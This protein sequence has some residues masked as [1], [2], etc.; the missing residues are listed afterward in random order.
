[1]A[2]LLHKQLT[3]D[4]IGAYYEVYNHTARTYPEYIYDNA[5]AEELRRRQYSVTQLSVWTSLSFVFNSHPSV[6]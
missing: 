6:L 4:V 3:G 5:M 2:E 1:M